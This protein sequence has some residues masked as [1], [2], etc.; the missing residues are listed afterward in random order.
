MKLTFLDIL[1]KFSMK[2]LCRYFKEVEGIDEAASLSLQMGHYCSDG[3]LCSFEE[4][5]YRKTDLSKGAEQSQ[6]ADFCQFCG[7][8]DW[9]W[10]KRVAHDYY[11]LM[12]MLL[13]LLMTVV[14]ACLYHAFL[15]SC[16]QSQ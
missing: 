14:I 12:W 3:Y 1:L 8:P 10:M 13:F 11:F 9:P 15:V 5:I 6:I 7:Y 4:C 16:S 2:V